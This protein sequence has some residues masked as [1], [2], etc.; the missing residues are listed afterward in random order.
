MQNT[1]EQVNGQAPVETV[2]RESWLHQFGQLGQPHTSWMTG[3]IE[4]AAVGFA[5]VTHETRLFVHANRRM[6]ALTGYSLAELTCLP[7]QRLVHPDDRAVIFEQYDRLLAG[8]LSEFTAERRWVRKDGRVIWVYAKVSVAGA[9][10]GSPAQFVLVAEDITDRKRLQTELL[11][12]REQ[13]QL[14]QDATGVSTWEIDVDHDVFHASPEM[15]RLCGLPDAALDHRHALDTIHPDDRPIVDKAVASAIVDGRNATYQHRVV[16]PGGETRWLRS[17]CRV[18]I[19]EVT[20]VRRIMGV[21]LDITDQKEAELRIERN[22]QRLRRLIDRLPDGAIHLESGALH[23]N[24]AAERLLGHTPEDLEAVAL[25]FAEAEQ[26]SALDELTAGEPPRRV[27][28]IRRHD[29]ARRVVEFSGYSDDDIQVWLLHDITA[30]RQVQEEL[31]RAK[32][33]SEAASRAKSEFLANMSHEIRTPMNGVIGMTELLVASGLK[34]DQ[35]EYAH[36]V[37]RS[38]D[39]LLTLINDILD[40]SKIEAGKLDLDS[41]DFPL[42]QTIHEALQPLALRADEK[43]LELLCHTMAD[44]PEFVQGDPTRL[45]QIL[46]NLVGNAI[47]FTPAG[48]IEVSVSIE[49]VHADAWDLHFRVKD[50][51]IGVPLEKQ[52]AIFAAFSQADAST[53][54]KY[55]GTGLGLSICTRLVQMMQGRLWIESEPGV[56]S[57]FHFTARYLRPVDPGIRPFTKN[58]SCLRGRRILLVDDNATNR[59][60]LAETFARWGML[61]ESASSVA[62]AIQVLHPDTPVHPPISFVVTDCH[63]PGQDGF[64]LLDHIKQDAELKHNP[65]VMLTSGYQQKD[66]HHGESA[67]LAALLMKPVASHALMDTILEVVCSSEHRNSKAAP[68]HLQPAAPARRLQILLAEDNPINQRVGIALLGRLG[69]T[70]ELVQ[71]GAQAVARIQEQSFDVVFMDIEMP[72]MDGWAASAAIRA[73][74]NGSGRKIPIIAMTA[75]AM[76][77][78]REQ[79]LA[80]GMDA[81]VSKPVSLESLSRAIDEVS[82][83]TDWPAATAPTAP[84]A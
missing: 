36:I 69:H 56:G 21:S 29:G 73:W 25:A 80:A 17:H 18:V 53:T 6:S 81:Y 74:E 52:Q 58:P 49:A 59:R 55:G 24:R 67:Q 60:I 33:A 51:G 37:K 11:V 75:H 54:R 19:D 64:A 66:R 79:C 63:M 39:S 45:R 1:D 13:L 9:S 61:V 10:G 20:G 40:F 15:L 47:K 44:V 35:L 83:H 23:L 14:I 46:T 5:L 65:V 31:E 30:L 34:P 28:T 26:Q 48:E 77:G 7:L 27:A 2:P 84:S 4:A 76:A 3:A 42:G 50:T 16:L 71:N 8:Q 32:D 82:P 62:E 38:A 57:T 70:V 43:G 12:K 22:E 78:Y 68:I 41:V 72:E